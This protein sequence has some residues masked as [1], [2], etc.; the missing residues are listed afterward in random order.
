MALTRATRLPCEGEDGDFTNPDLYCF[1]LDGR[2]IR[3]LGEGSAVFIYKKRIYWE[4]IKGNPDSKI[5]YRFCSAGM[6]GKNKKQVTKW[7]PQNE[8]YKIARKVNF[9]NQKTYFKIRKNRNWLK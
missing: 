2:K 5:Y 3:K 6:N 4:Q 7:I 1:N 8:Y 9:S